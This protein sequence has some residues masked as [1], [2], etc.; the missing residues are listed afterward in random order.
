MRRAIVVVA[1]FLVGVGLLA[2]ASFASSLVP[3]GPRQADSGITLAIQM[4]L[5]ADVRVLAR[6][7]EV[8]TRD[9]VVYLTGV[10]D[11]EESRCEAGRLAWRA[12]GVGGVI[13]DLTVE[14]RTVG[15]WVEDVM[16]SSRVK[17]K[18]I[19]KSRIKAGDVDVGSSRGVVTLI[20]R[21][22]SEAVRSDAERIARETAGVRDVKNQILVGRIRS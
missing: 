5:E 10:V 18:L 22:P 4:A 17:S 13:N 7:V 20:G 2:L 8:E 11:T 16:I 19:A 1:G 3:R 15:S 9:G 12:S 6:L 14:E 21:V